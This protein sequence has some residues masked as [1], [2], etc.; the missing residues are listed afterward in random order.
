VK[1][2]VE[3]Q[4]EDR[5]GERR[6]ASRLALASFAASVLCVGW[7]ITRGID[8]SDESYYAVFLHAWLKEGIAASPFLLLH[9]T[10]VLLIYPFALVY[11]AIVGSTDGLMLFLRCLYLAF[12]TTAALAWVRF[13]RQAGTG[14][15]RWLAGAVLVAFVPYNLPAPSYNTVGLQA[16]IVACSTLGCAVLVAQRG[17]R[18][19]R[20]LLFSALAWVVALVAYPPLLA[21]LA[22]LF[23]GLVLVIQPGRRFAWFYLLAIAVGQVLAWAVVFSVFGLRRLADGVAYQAMMSSTFE[24]RAIPA[25]VI[26]VLAHNRWFAAILAVAAVL[27]V[28]RSRIPATLAAVMDALL[29]GSVLLVPPALHSISHGAML[30]SAL[31]GLVVLGDLRRKADATSRLLSLLYLTSLIAGLAMAGTATLGIL[32][33]PVGTAVAAVIAVVVAARRCVLAGH[34]RFAPVAAAALWVTLLVGLPQ[35]YYGE[36][37][38]DRPAGRARIHGSAFAGLAAT[39]D[40]ARMVEIARTAIKQYERPSDTIAVLGRWPGIYLLSNARIRTL[41]PYTLTPFAQPSGLR[42]THDYYA[43]LE[44]RPALV[45]LYRDPHYP[46]VNPFDPDFEKWYGLRANFPTPL[47]TL[48]V[49]RR[50][51]EPR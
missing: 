8:L 23:L 19:T 50:S 35:N 47:G 45:L 20:N 17:E 28:L 16:L 32:K 12:A 42:A 3:S 34:A 2:A 51:D 13:L 9:Q 4:A 38:L 1:A 46:F 39:L 33:V 37:P 7:R 43:A 14:P 5:W 48:A 21:P 31:G 30:V 29:I 40:D 41:A 24:P 49:F 11:R 6:W 10:S 15:I 36:L 18:A 44:N 25:H 22:A 27:A 26:D